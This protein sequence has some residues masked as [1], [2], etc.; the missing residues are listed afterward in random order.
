[1]PESYPSTPAKPVISFC[2]TCRDRLWQLRQ[3][4]ASNLAEIGPY[5]HIVLVD[6]GST[7]G[8]SSWIWSN[9]EDAIERQQ[10]VFFEVENEVRWNCSKAKNLAHRLS[11]GDYLF[12]LD[13]DNFITASDLQLIEAAAAS[14]RPCHQWSGQWPDGSYGRIGLPR[15]LFLQLG[16]YDEAMLP[17]GWQDIDLL[18]RLAAFGQQVTQLRPPAANAIQQTSEEKMAQFSNV[19]MPSKDLYGCITRL[20]QL[21]S[22]ARQLLEGTV[23]C[24]DLSSFRGKLNGR[25]STIDGFDNITDSGHI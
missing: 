11:V 23:R 16:G 19:G 24:G 25:P 4:L 21:L 13:A 8:L 15:T 22:N 7:D 2:T 12:N 9:F 1:M 6:F 3:T 20:N 17:M 14:N 5:H 10:L 18:N